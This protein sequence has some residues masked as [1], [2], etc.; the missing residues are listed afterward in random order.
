MKPL[1][2][3][4]IGLLLL[5]LLLAADA[6][7]AAQDQGKRCATVFSAPSEIKAKTLE[8]LHF[9]ARVVLRNHGL[10][11]VSDKALA[12]ELPEPDDPWLAECIASS[13]CLPGLGEQLGVSHLLVVAL[14]KSGSKIEGKVKLWTP[15][16]ET[17]F[18]EIPGAPRR[19]FQ[20]S[21]PKAVEKACLD[22]EAAMTKAEQE[23]RAAE[24]LA[25]E[26]KASPPEVL[27]A[28]ED[29]TRP[30]E[31]TAAPVQDATEA[32][33]EQQMA[34]QNA[35]AEETPQ[36]IVVGQSCINVFQPL[37]AQPAAA[38][39]VDDAPVFVKPKVLLLPIKGLTKANTHNKATFT[40]FIESA[41]LERFRLKRIDFVMQCTQDG[42]FDNRGRS[43]D[44]QQLSLEKIQ[45]KQLYGVEWVFELRLEDW[46]EEYKEKKYEIESTFGVK[47]LHATWE[48]ETDDTVTVPGMLD[49]LTF[50]AQDAAHE[51]KKAA[52][53]QVGKAIPGD[54]SGGAVGEVLGAVSDALSKSPEDEEYEYRLNQSLKMAGDR[55]ALVIKK[56]PRFRLASPLLVRNDDELG[57]GI[58]NEEGVTLN[59]TYVFT[60]GGD[61]DDWDGF[62]RVVELGTGGTTGKDNPSFV[63]VI[64]DYDGSED[65]LQVLEYP[66][67]GIQVG[68]VG[69]FLPIKHKET[70]LAVDDHVSKAAFGMPALSLDVRFRIPWL[71]IKE[72]YETNN[73]NFIIDFP[74]T[75]L[76][77]DV[78]LEKRWLWGRFAPLIGV[79][80]TLGMIGV[81][82]PNP[83]GGSESQTAMAQLHGADGYV[84]FAYFLHPVWTIQLYAGY[85]QYFSKASQFKLED[86][87]YYGKDIYGE[88]WEVDLSGPAVKLAVSYEF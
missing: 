13:E 2:R 88:T 35:S 27:A 81:P 8:G 72:F 51:A 32:E 66:L 55:L 39:P 40:Q 14:A 63:E 68:F 70:Y 42:K 77:F 46:K 67:I 7:T 48:Q 45:G 6:A 50:A 52:M 65:G 71:P 43:I 47:V 41:L 24:V 49:F 87:V 58:G 80:Y 12:E 44:H 79:R 3:F 5:G 29:A 31:P 28:P 54:G 9:K 33:L 56:I 30:D 1:A 19:G 25:S 21:F 83:K 18:V 73:I 26:Q 37:P 16:V 82:I 23:R 85:R 74:L 57:V 20:R 34:E 22:F 10:E 53:E 15:G 62:G 69:G 59:D 75:V 78:G 17:S 38:K 64:G 4:S 11:P 84:G 60:R 76:S 36:E 86:Q 61:P